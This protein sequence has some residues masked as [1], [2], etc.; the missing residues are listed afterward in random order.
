MNII[1]FGTSQFAVSSLRAIAG[2]HKILAVITRPDQ[3]AGRGMHLSL[4]P[5]KIEAGH[6]GLEVYQPDD[7][8]SEGS[9][10]FL[11][12]KKADLFVIIAYG[13][14]LSKELLQLPK[15]Y[16]VNLH[17]SLLPKYRGAA[18][19]NWAV[20]NGEKDTG[21]TII[22][23]SEKLDAGDIISGQSIYISAQDTSF[24][25]YNKLAHIGA[26]TLKVTLD[27]IESKRE[28]F[29]KQDESK[30][31][32]APKLKKTD[33]LINWSKDA[34]TIE[35]LIRGA[36]PWPGAYTHLDKKLLKIFKAQKIACTCDK[37]PGS[38]VELEKKNFSVCCGKDAL[39]ILEV[40]VEGKK[41]MT[42]EEFLR[43]AH[44]T[45]GVVMGTDT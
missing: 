40:Q 15:K 32:L 6:L 30:A 21:V 43:G 34:E 38:I 29:S 14:I 1:F 18:P 24:D 11:K 2:K 20:I 22:K 35:N 19:Y 8:S 27:M 13:K 10:E 12:K 23:V 25:I 3:K 31:T 9:L 16:C 36:Q 42:S 39:K 4:S 41:H 37:L 17:A 26:E 33:G 44:L 28:K 45:E 5:V 7:P